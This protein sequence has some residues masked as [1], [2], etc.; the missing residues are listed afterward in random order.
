MKRVLLLLCVIG[1]S[2]KPEEKKLDKLGITITVPGNWKQKEHNASITLASGLDGVI[3]RAEDE[4]IKTIDDAKARLIQGYKLRSE[5]TLPNGAFAFD[6]D[7]DY[8]TAAKPMVLR[9][10]E[11]LLPTAKGHV[12]CK[13]QLQASQDPGPIEKACASMKPI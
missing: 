3:L 5:K 1:C 8:G 12:S 6:Y 7:I 2:S 4:P 13:L 9:H 10:I 11:V